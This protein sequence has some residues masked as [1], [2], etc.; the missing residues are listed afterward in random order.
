MNTLTVC[1]LIKKGK[2]SGTIFHDWYGNLRIIL[3]S[4]ESA[5]VLA[6]AYQNKFCEQDK[7][8]LLMLEIMLPKLQKE[9]GNRI[10][11]DMLNELKDIFQTQASQELY[12]IQKLLNSYRMEEGQSVSSY[13]SKMKSYIDRL[14]RLRHPMPSVLVVNTIVGS[15]PNSFD[16]LFMN[17]NM[18]GWEK[19]LGELYSMINTAKM[20]VLSKQVVPS[21]HMSMEGDV[22]KNNKSYSKGKRSSKDKKKILPPLKRRAS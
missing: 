20:N 2:L 1:S 19:S 4:E 12:A 22:R 21:M 7:I 14:E 8:T 17:Y 3:K 9:M 11:Y 10:S 16:N 15:L 18:N 13:I 6:T 5:H